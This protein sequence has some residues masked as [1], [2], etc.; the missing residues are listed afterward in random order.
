[1]KDNIG[2]DLNIG[3]Y[4][5]CLS[6]THKNTVQQIKKFRITKDHFGDR[7]AVDFVGGSWLL[8]YNTI[9]LTALGITD[10]KPS[11]QPGCDVL[12]NVL[13][14][15][16]KVLYRHPM[17]FYAEMGTV[18]QL[19]A[20]SCLLEITPNRFGETECRKKFNEIISLTAI[21]QEAIVIKHCYD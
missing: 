14:H 18:K 20:K 19:A 21:G 4:V 5:F 17:E 12:G 13:R 16:D 15:G 1:M 3:D 7:D 8:A 2:S 6:G 9:S 10:T 11:V